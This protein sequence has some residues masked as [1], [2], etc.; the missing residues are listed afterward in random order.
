MVVRSGST[1]VISISMTLIV[2]YQYCIYKIRYKNEVYNISYAKL[3]KFL[4]ESEREIL[5]VFLI[6]GMPS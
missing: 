4:P 1:S 6:V 5:M 3:G 2:G